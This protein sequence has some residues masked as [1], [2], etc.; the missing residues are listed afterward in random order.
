M[1]IDSFLQK[2]E[3]LK[4]SPDPL[5]QSSGRAYIQAA[6][7]G[8]KIFFK[9]STMLMLAEKMKDFEGTV[10]AIERMNPYGNAQGAI[11]AAKRSLQNYNGCWIQFDKPMKIASL[12]I[13]AM[14]SFVPSAYMQTGK[15][16]YFLL[17][18]DEQGDIPCTLE[19][20]PGQEWHVNLASHQC[21]FKQCISSSL[22]EACKRMLVIWSQIFALSS[23][24][25]GQYLAA[26]RYEE[27]EFTGM[28]RVPRQGN[29]KKSKRVP[30]KHIF[31]TIDANE[32]VITVPSEPPKERELHGSWIANAEAEGDLDYQECRTRPFARTYRHERYV[33]MKGNS[34]S[35][36]EGV[37]RR[38]PI[39]KSL[40][41]KHVTKVKASDYE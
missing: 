18:I 29:D 2:W 39:R 10:R 32:I 27:K 36:P 5:L 8:D 7:K 30:V 19:S 1:L 34:T 31:K 24:I 20:T 13:A 9:E 14:F 23:I 41:G 15:D 3:K 22:C 11:E 12:S 40:V 6:Q 21:P 26:T 38:H 37:I 4:T 35:F 33:N 16:V 25:A 28:R 17:L